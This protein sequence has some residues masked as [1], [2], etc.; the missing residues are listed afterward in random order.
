MQMEKEKEKESEGTKEASVSQAGGGSVNVEGHIT[1]SR[2][3]S[4]NSF[5]SGRTGKT[6]FS[7]HAGVAH[8]IVPVEVACDG[9]NRV[10]LVAMFGVDM[11]SRKYYPNLLPKVMKVSC[12]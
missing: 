3:T 10:L 6:S 11:H 1:N 5:E 9:D 8:Q 2:S 12:Y 7:I 4:K